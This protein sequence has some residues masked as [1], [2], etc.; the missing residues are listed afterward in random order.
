MNIVIQGVEICG[1]IAVLAEEMRAQGHSVVTIADHNPLYTKQYD[2]GLSNF[3]DKSDQSTFRNKRNRLSKAMSR[4]A[5]P[6]SNRLSTSMRTKVCLKADLYLQVWSGWQG[7]YALLE[8]L[9]RRGV[10]IATMF[11][12]S[13]VRYYPLFKKQYGEEDWVFPQQY[14]ASRDEKLRR[15][16][17]HEKYADA[18]FSVPDQMGLATRPYHHIQVPI[19]ADD[20][21]FNV[22][23]RDRPLVVHAPT[24][25]GVKGSEVIESALEQLRAEGVPFD[26]LPID[27]IPHESLQNILSVADVLVD[28]VILHG[29]GWLGFEAMAAGCAG[30]T[31]FLDS[32][33]AC[34][35]PPVHS[36]DRR[37]IVGRLREL[38]TDQPRRCKLAVDGRRYVEANNS[39][40]K[41]VE[42]IIQ[43]TLHSSASVKDYVPEVNASL[44]RI[45]H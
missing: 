9:S 7:E 44:P 15:L 31:R 36:I 19:N 26:Y 1:V 35:R 34:F 5:R 40:S 12:G 24:N 21:D 3:F 25:R 16:Q 20:I 33:P 43:C 27:R 18:I 22:P 38:L 10:K 2:H 8:Q 14:G 28:Q 17:M 23:G 41:V 42:N 29:P 45:A 30:A 13:E 37:N 39:V 32:S 4:V 11:M 6:L